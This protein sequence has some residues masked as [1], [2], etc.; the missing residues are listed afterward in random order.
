M[1]KR[2]T[3]V[4]MVSAVLF[5]AMLSSSSAIDLFADPYPQ[6]TTKTCQSYSLALALAALGDPAIPIRSFEELRTAEKQIRDILKHQPNGPLSHE[7]WKT[8]V[9][10][11]TSNRY[12]LKI[13]TFGSDY[14]KWINRVKELTVLTSTGD[15]LIASLTGQSFP[16]VLTSVSVIESSTYD[17]GH[18]ISIL[19]VAGS[20]LNS[21]TKIVAFNSAIKGL[22]GAINMC[23]DGSS[24]GSEPGDQ[25]YTAGVFE[26]ND[27][28]LKSFSPGGY[29][30]LYL[31]RN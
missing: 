23:V 6:S 27:F 25:I 13:E 18:I 8:G 9:P 16:V 14:V 4:L 15:A 31:Q 17:S 12:R 2:V 1:I 5:G 22:G 11:F 26:T 30:L 3:S 19:G 7:S 28:K 29:R 10:I 21:S 20:G 24:L